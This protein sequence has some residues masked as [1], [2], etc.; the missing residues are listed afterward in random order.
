MAFLR[1]LVPLIIQT[2]FP[3]ETRTVALIEVANDGRPEVAADPFNGPPPTFEQAL[4]RLCS[5]PEQAANFA[6]WQALADSA[7]PHRACFAAPAR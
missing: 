2:T 6:G 7:A 4:T 5:A 1:R 3:A